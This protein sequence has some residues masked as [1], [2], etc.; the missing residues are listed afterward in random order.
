MDGI[1]GTYFNDVNEECLRRVAF[2]IM[3]CLSDGRAP[4]RSTVKDAY[5]RFLKAH[6]GSGRM[7]KLARSTLINGVETSLAMLE[8]F[9]HLGAV[10]VVVNHPYELKFG[11][12]TIAGAIDGI[13]IKDDE[14]RAVKIVY[15]SK[16]DDVWQNDIEVPLSILAARK[17]LLRPISRI[18][19]YYTG[20]GTGE[21]VMT[22]RH[23][24]EVAARVVE[25]VV[26]SIQGEIYYPSRQRPC[27]GC[28]YY[29]WCADG[30]WLG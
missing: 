3:Y 21:E 7:N 28:Q 24:D 4:T 16:G 30:K 22:A 27:R 12:T 1:G 23:R 20:S 13:V 18:V 8:F 29:Q 25:A 17:V 9:K 26:R 5:G 19:V 15:G 2:Y 14:F 6:L 10:P 11:A